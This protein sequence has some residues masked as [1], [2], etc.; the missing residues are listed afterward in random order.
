MKSPQRIYYPPS[1]SNYM[2]TL[3]DNLDDPYVDNR[4]NYPNYQLDPYFSYKQP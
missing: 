2:Y 4:N 3:P 1:S